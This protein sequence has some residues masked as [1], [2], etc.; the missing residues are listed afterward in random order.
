MNNKLY[1]LMNWPE[2]EEIIYSESDNPH[3][4]MGT[5]CLGPM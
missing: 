5:A 3:R 4:A 1:K 2:M